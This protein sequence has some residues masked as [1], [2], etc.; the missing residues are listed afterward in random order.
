MAWQQLGTIDLS[1]DWQF[2]SVPILRLETFRITHL[3]NETDYIHGK[4]IVSQAFNEPKEFYDTRVIYPSQK[5]K[6]ITMRTPSELEDDVGVYRYLALKLS[7]R[8]YR[9]S[10]G[11]QVRVDIN[12]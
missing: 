5:L 3:Y 4:V 6:I 8:Y 11:W 2:L 9:Y 1:Y 7:R 12:I 10:I